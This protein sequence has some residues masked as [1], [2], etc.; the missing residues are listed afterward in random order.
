MRC[1]PAF[2]GHIVSSGGGDKYFTTLNGAARPVQAHLATAQARIEGEI[3]SSVRAMLPAYKVIFDR[4]KNRA[5]VQ[6]PTENVTP[7]RA[8]KDG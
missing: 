4:V 8:P 1:G 2:V 6:K 3:V 7:L 5:I